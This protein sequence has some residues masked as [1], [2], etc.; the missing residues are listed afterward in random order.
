RR[1]TLVAVGARTPHQESSLGA[2][3]LQQIETNPLDRQYLLA[4]LTAK[5]VQGYAIERIGLGISHTDAQE[6]LRVCAGSF[7]EVAAIFDQ[8][9]EQEVRNLHLSWRL[10]IRRARVGDDLLMTRFRGLSAQAQATAEIVAV[11]GHEL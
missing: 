11:A 6:L 10:P 5:E 8:L 1:G 3:L 4:P 9:D 2:H 7:L